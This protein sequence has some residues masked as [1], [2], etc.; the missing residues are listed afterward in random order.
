[1]VACYYVVGNETYPMLICYSAEPSGGGWEYAVH[2]RF[3]NT[4][5]MQAFLQHPY[6]QQT[7][8]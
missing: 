5:S 8:L 6:V 7:Y 3:R 2:F 1:M 4:A